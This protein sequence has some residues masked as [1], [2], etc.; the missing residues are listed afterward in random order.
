MSENPMTGHPL[1]FAGRTDIGRS[2]RRNEDAFFA[3]S[4]PGGEG[5]T[6]LAVA[7]GLGGHAR[8]DWASARA[9]ELLAAELGPL[10]EAHG[11]DRGL[12]EAI[13]H[14]NW[15]IRSEARAMEAYGA[16]TTLVL[17]L[18]HGGEYWWLNVGDSRLYS[19]RV[20]GMRQ[21][22]TDHSWVAEQV[23]AGLLAPEDARRHPNRNVVTRTVG[24]DPDVVPDV[25]G[26]IQLA[27][28]ETLLACSDGLFGP[29]E[30]ADIAAVLAESQ[31]EEAC[32]KLIEL[33][34]EAGGPDNIT[35]VVGRP[36]S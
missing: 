29:V 6:L 36:L 34:N 16:A 25:A 14:I 31:P 9:L 18:F 28:G 26:P 30:D 17:A 19:Y 5:W 33:A 24:F 8:G 11:A 7:D 20:E 21:V 13:H 2:R 22:S 15:S 1:S 23:A 4:L 27:P 35:V 3:G 32:R 12:R 10:V